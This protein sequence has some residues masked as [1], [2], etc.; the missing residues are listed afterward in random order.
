MVAMSS[1]RRF[2]EG[3][4]PGIRMFRSRLYSGRMLFLDA[5]HFCFS[6]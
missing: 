3:R 2:F 4:G 5:T 1:I 6:R